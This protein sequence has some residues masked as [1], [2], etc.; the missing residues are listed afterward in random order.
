MIRKVGEKVRKVQKLSFRVYEN[1]LTKREISG[2]FVVGCNFV[3]IAHES[4]Q[5]NRRRGELHQE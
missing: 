5:L 3:W 1:L 4:H 2:N